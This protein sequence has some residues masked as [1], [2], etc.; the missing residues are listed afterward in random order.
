M[1]VGSSR[2]PRADDGQQQRVQDHH[3]RQGRHA[4]LPHNGIDPVP[5]ACQM[6]QAFQTIVT[7]NKRPIDTA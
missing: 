1:P 3:H 5:V 6:V 4:A 2:L 7:R